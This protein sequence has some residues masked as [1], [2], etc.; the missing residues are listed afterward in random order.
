MS[1]WKVDWFDLTTGVFLPIGVP[2]P[3]TGIAVTNTSIWV[4]TAHGVLEQI[5]RASLKVTPHTIPS[6]TNV[7]AFGLGRLWLAYADT[8]SLIRIDPG[9]GNDIGRPSHVAE[10]T[11][12]LAFAAGYAWGTSLATNELQK[13]DPTDGRVLG[14]ITLQAEPQGL[15]AVRGVLYAITADGLLNEIRVAPQAANHD[16][17]PEYE[18]WASLSW[19]HVI[20]VAPHA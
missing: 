13:I 6:G 2:W 4:A 7:M 11:T 16:V 17:G 20:T 18:G 5:N 3:P 14:H 9:S 19:P 8:G 10:Q 15:V 1:N 12:A